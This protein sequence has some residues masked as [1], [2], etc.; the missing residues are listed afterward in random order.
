[1]AQNE[2]SNFMLCFILINSVMPPIFLTLEY[3]LISIV[4]HTKMATA[5]FSVN[6]KNVSILGAFATSEDLKMMQ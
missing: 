6:V 5:I 1:M 2:I 3:S 4:V